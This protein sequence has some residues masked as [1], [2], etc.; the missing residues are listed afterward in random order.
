VVGGS[1]LLPLFA[2]ARAGRSATHRDQGPLFTQVDTGQQ[3]AATARALA[4]K[5]NCAAALEAFDRAL[6][7]VDRSWRSAAIAGSATSNS[8]NAFPA[9][10]DYRAYL[11][12]LPD[13]PDADDIRERL[14]RLEAQTGVGGPSPGWARPAR[15]L[16]RRSPTSPRIVS[17][18]LTSDDGKGKPGKRNAWQD[19][20]AGRGEPTTGTTTR[21]RRPLRLGTGGDLR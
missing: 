15:S 7:C 6:H 2:G 19:V 5:G 4:A 9:M 3:A 13:A 20:R 11:V 1:L 21:C 17:G 10:D 8:A 12:A 18:P 14:E 16:P